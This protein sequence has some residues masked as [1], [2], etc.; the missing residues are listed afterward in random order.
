MQSDGRRGDTLILEEI[1]HA[2]TPG[3]FENEIMKLQVGER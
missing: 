2:K 3:M 1:L